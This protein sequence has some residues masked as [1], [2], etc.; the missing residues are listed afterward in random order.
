MVRNYFKIAVRNLTKHSFYSFINIIGLAIGLACT[1]LILIYVQ[2]ELTYD[3][4][5][6][7]AERIYRVATEIDFGGRHFNMPNC[8]APLAA[9]VFNDYP[10]VIASMR[11][12]E[13]GRF[14]VRVDEDTY[15]EEGLVYADSSIFS[16]FDVP[17]TAGATSALDRPNSIILDETTASKY[18]GEENPIGKRLLLDNDRD[19]EVT[20]VFED[21][22]VNSHFHYNLILSMSSSE[23]SKHT[24]WLSNN[25]H[26]YLLLE[27]NTSAEALVAKFPHMIDKYIGPQVTQA[28]D[29]TMEEFFESG[30][31][32]RYYLQPLVDIHLYSQLD[33]ELEANGDI[34]YV[35]LFSGIA[36]LILALAC[37][38]FMNLSTARS[39]NRAKEVGVRK[40][41]G[42][43]KSHLV[44]QFLSES[45]LISSIAMILSVVLALLMLPTF[46]SLAGKSL[47]LPFTEWPF[48]GL[49]ITGAIFIGVIAGV[50]PAFFLSSFQPIQVLKGKLNLGVKSGW[51]RST[52]VVFQFAISTILIIGTLVIYKQLNFIQNKKLG[53]NKDQIILIEDAYALEDNL[54]AYKKDITNISGV[55]STTVSGYLPVGSNRSDTMF[56]LEGQTPNEETM[57]SMQIWNVDHDYIPTMGMTVVEGRN[58]SEQNAADSSGMIVN[59]AAAKKLGIDQDPIGAHVVTFADMPQGDEEPQLELFTVVGVIEDFHFES[60]KE[61]IMPLSLVMGR[62]RSYLSVK[63]ATTDVQNILGQLEDRW[64]SLAEGQPFSYSFMDQK[65]DEIYAA[66]ARIGKLFSAFAILAIFIAC[67]GLFGLAA[68]TAEQRTKEIGVRKVMGATVGGIVVLLSKEFGKLVLVAFVVA[69]PVAWYFTDQW[70]QDFEFRINLSPWIFALS[71]LLTFLV[72][73]ITMS[74]QSI[75]AATMS[76][77]KSLRDE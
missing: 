17:L 23:H 32:Y 52:L 12:R 64:N 48:Y 76:P 29:L 8:P 27:E 5:H 13:Q 24:M 44:K 22:P 67:L 10:E 60:M 26:T 71:G 74:Y 73:W 49:L 63:I 25:Y 21:M 61:S 34:R 18:F 19:V 30:N 33:N 47:A 69:V 70:L 77:S 38:N 58:F 40:V 65:F 45:I 62:S 15:R 14:L 20:G 37:I 2:N 53:F 66:E 35:Y 59:L 11:L 41:L 3:K 55:Q 54:S 9:A 50:Y 75:K 16:V 46:N 51:L 36:L 56:W 39:A 7:K 57:V 68:F 6:S 4:H 1:L 31:K 42:S 28:L 72:A 43:Y